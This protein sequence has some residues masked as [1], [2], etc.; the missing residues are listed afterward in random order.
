MIKTCNDYGLD[1]SKILDEVSNQIVDYYKGK[2]SVD[3]SQ[4]DDLPF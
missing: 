2:S 3:S 1:Y 4:D